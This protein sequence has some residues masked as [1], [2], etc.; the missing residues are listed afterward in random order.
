MEPKKVQS[1]RTSKT[2]LQAIYLSP[3]TNNARRPAKCGP[4]DTK[5]VLSLNQEIK[6]NI[7]ATSFHNHLALSPAR[8]LHTY[9]RVVVTTAAFLGDN[10]LDCNVKGKAANVKNAAPEEEFGGVAGRRLELTMRAMQ[11]TNLHRPRGSHLCRKEK[12]SES[13]VLLAVWAM[14][15][16]FVIAALAKPMV[17]GF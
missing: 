12:G 6:V 16:R 2:N 15:D 7:G 17:N 11:A 1:S 9:S 5:S 4:V 14:I 3:N 10:T 13:S 8:M